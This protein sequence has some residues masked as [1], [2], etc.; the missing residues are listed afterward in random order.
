MSAACPARWELRNGGSRPTGD[1]SSRRDG[2]AVVE[3]LEHDISQ[4]P[5]SMVGGGK[6]VNVNLTG[7]K[8][9][10]YYGMS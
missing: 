3:L 7:M 2:G 6:S 4:K 10:E 9:T 5:R 8:G 1:S